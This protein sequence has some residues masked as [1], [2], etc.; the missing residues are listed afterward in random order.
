M[1]YYFT[2]QMNKK[3]LTKVCTTIREA[4]TFFDILLACKAV[5]I[6]VIT[7]TKRVKD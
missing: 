6:K 1:I 3:T 4:E 7:M 5:Y 2:Y